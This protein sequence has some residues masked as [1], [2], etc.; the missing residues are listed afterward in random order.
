MAGYWDDVT[1]QNVANT[2]DGFKEFQIG[3]N[4]AYV[5]SVE[6]KVSSAGNKM[7]VI[8]FANDDGAEIKHYIVEGESKL[9]KLKQL[10]IAFG[11]PM[12]S[13]NTKEWMGKR[14]IVVCKQGEPWDGKIYNKVSYLKPKANMAPRNPPPMNNS[15][16]NPPSKPPAEPEYNYQNENGE[17]KDDIPF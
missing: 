14:G 6:E 4:D 5:C 10:Y 17:F 16:R 11:I 15:L 1:P 9:Q 8:T 2:Q 13:R 7:L 3:D 12:G